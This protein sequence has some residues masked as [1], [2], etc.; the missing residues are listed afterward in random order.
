[1]LSSDR[2]NEALSALGAILS[3][4]GQSAEV[5]AIGGGSLLLLGL[6][7]RPTRDLDLVARVEG[8]RYV[9]AETLPGSLAEAVGDV[10]EAMGLSQ[11][12]FNGGPTDLLRFGLPAGFE[13]RVQTRSFSSLTVHIASRRD[14]ICF[15]LYAAVDQGP[16]SKHFVDLK[17]L[18][19]TIDEL[20]TARAWCVTHDTSE[21]FAQMLS[22]ALAS[23]GYTDVDV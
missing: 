19:P 6:V 23:L 15:K 20:R 2:L 5:V 1:M 16:K 11:K 3:S 9:S 4:R 7:E 8:G 22:Q 17:Q 18:R 13:N 12:W 21:P 14:Q 10:A